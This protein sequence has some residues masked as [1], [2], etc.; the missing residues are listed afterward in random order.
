MAYKYS[1]SL[2]FQRYTLW[3]YPLLADRPALTLNPNYTHSFIT[4]KRNLT[5]GASG[6]ASKRPRIASS[7]PPQWLIKLYSALWGQLIRDQIIRRTTLT[8]AQFLKLN[9]DLNNKNALRKANDHQTTLVLKEKLAVLGETVTTAEA[10]RE[11]PDADNPH[12][13]T[14]TTAETTDNDKEADQDEE[15]D[16]PRCEYKQYFPVVVDY[17]DLSVIGPPDSNPPRCP[18][19]IYIRKE[20]AIFDGLL[21][22]ES[23]QSI[24]ASAVVSGQPGI[25]E[26]S[27]IHLILP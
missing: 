5:D 4:V 2:Y 17:V 19:T 14:V 6:S 9:D 7:D 20:Y 26:I 8:F 3:F 10:I 24:G 15:D 27:F 23:E 13:E 1:F 22:H 12:R 21:K 25:G 11:D 16:D 18:Y